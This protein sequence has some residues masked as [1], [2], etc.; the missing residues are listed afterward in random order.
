MLCDNALS[1]VSVKINLR[2]IW[3]QVLFESNVE[4]NVS[5]LSYQK[6][7]QWY[8]HNDDI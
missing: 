8:N 4:K 6:V 3:I 7:R 2:K 5:S 1:K